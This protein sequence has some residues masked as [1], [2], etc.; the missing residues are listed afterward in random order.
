MT[1]ILKTP[2]F[3]PRPQEHG[4]SLVEV[5]VALV[6][7]SIGML[8]LAGMQTRSLRDNH[9]SLM[10]SQ[11][12]TA[13]NDIIDRMRANPVQARLG[14]YDIGLGTSPVLNPPP[15]PI[16]NADLVEWKGNPAS[17]VEDRWG[18][19]RLPLGDGSVAMVGNK[20]TV[21]VIWDDLRSGVANAQIQIETEL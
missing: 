6:I 20:I 11:A 7:L 15:A 17:D 5:L 3:A 12:T 9:G 18:L 2:F 14:L 8:G 4:F 1:P 13:A 21:I 16:F 10:R 19:A